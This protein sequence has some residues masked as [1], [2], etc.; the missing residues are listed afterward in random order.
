MDFLFNFWH[1]LQRLTM[2]T[3]VAMNK[4]IDNLKNAVM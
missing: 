2:P 3:N 1:P 4:K